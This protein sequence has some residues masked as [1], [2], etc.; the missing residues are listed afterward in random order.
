[1]LSL[2]IRHFWTVC[3]SGIIGHVAPCK[4]LPSLG[5]SFSGLNRAVASY[6]IIF[7]CTTAPHVHIHQLKDTRAVSSF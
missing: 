6:P 1:M 5:T 3:I 2:K 4:R 7:D